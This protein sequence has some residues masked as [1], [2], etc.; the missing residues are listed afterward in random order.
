M[1]SAALIGC[2]S[3]KVYASKIRLFSI[4]LGLIQRKGQGSFQDFAGA[5][6]GQ[7]YYSSWVIVAGNTG[8][9]ER[10]APVGAALLVSS[11]KDAVMTQRVRL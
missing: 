9:K 7:G 10:A 6:Y 3:S 4:L 8:Y 2:G 11:P 1:L 5:V